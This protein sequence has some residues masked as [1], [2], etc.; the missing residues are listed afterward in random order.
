MKRITRVYALV[1]GEVVE[2]DPNG[3]VVFEWDTGESIEIAP[4]ITEELQVFAFKEVE[5]T[6]SNVPFATE[7]AAS[8]TLGLEQRFEGN[9]AYVK[10]HA[11]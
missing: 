7:D 10:P 8:N 11:V 5:I 2:L 6:R 3:T 1:K 9:T 4:T